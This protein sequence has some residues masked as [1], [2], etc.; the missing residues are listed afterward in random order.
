MCYVYTL[1]FSPC[2]GMNAS[3]FSTSLN[4]VTIIPT[5]AERCLSFPFKS[6][7]SP[8]TH[9]SDD[10]LLLSHVLRQYIMDGERLIRFACLYAL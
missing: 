7:R 1:V 10:T 3:T 9:D 8:F 4:D 6:F 5:P 2:Y